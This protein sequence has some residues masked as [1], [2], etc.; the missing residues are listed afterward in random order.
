MLICSLQVYFSI[1]FVFYLSIICIVNVYFI[2]G[3][4]Q[5]LFGDMGTLIKYHYNNNN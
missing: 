4:I 5:K 1:L 3:P 2:Q